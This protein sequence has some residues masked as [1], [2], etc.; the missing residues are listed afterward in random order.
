MTTFIH[1]GGVSLIEYEDGKKLTSSLKPDFSFDYDELTFTENTKSYLLN[2]EVHQITYA[3]KQE[4]SSFISTVA[5]DKEAGV[6]LVKNNQARQF[7]ADTDWK[8]MRHI[9]EKALLKETSLS[10]DEYLDLEE[11]RDEASI[12]VE[13]IE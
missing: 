8:V 1:Q 13:A 6:Q 11:Q 3:Q 12:V 10:E 2:E 7:L 9:R 5:E 4:V